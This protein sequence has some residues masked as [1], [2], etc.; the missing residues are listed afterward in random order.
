MT[1]DTHIIYVRHI[2][3]G[4]FQMK[5]KKYQLPIKSIHSLSIY[6]LFQFLFSSLIS[7]VNNP[8]YE[9][10]YIFLSTLIPTAGLILLMENL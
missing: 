5:T 4:N 3:W 1:K 8:I 9:I 7:T 6:H 2:Y 10:M